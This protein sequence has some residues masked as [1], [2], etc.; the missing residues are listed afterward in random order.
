MNTPAAG[1]DGSYPADLDALCRRLRGEHVPITPAMVSTAR[2]HRIH[3]VLAAAATPHDLS[4]DAGAPLRTELRTAEMIEMMRG[5]TLRRLLDQLS[6]A[7]IAALLLKGAGLAY[8]LYPSA[9]LRPREDADLLIRRPDLDAAERSLTASGWARS[10]EPDAEL[11]STQRHYDLTGPAA[12]TERLDL[13]WKIAIP[14]IF[15]DAVT[16]EALM[17]RSVPVTALGPSAHTLST[18]DALFVACVHRV[19]HHQ[20][21]VELLWLWDIH[22]LASRLSVD[23]RASFVALA[24]RASMRAVC[25]RGLILACARFQ[26]AGALELISALQLRQGEPLE[27]SARFLVGNLRQVDLL[28]SDLSTLR[29]WQARVMLV[30]EHLFPSIAYMRS[31]YPRCPAAA[32]PLAY[33]HRIVRGAPKWFRR[34]G[35]VR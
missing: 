30:G 25:A 26:T 32:L 2:R 28:R 23:E 18:A 3:L 15:A 12:F 22:L 16:V 21:V 29:G 10:A 13:H 9:C 6:T 17:S 7:G 35:N 31:M 8:T 19:A 5:R 1:D 14:Q 20:D 33:A 4:T 34:P 24:T 11:A 27:P